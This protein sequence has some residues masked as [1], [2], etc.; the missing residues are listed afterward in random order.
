ME[1]HTDSIEKSITMQANAKFLPLMGI[2]PK[3][4]NKMNYFM[5]YGKKVKSSWM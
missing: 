3:A 2:L 5:H 4:L 1:R